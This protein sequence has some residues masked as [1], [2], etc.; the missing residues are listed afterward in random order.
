LQRVVVAGAG[1]IKQV[2][3]EKAQAAGASTATGARVTLAFTVG[4]AGAL[5]RA[6]ATGGEA[7]AAL[8]AC[9]EGVARGWRFPTGYD[10]TSSQAEFRFRTE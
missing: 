10:E 6:R 2:C 5:T 1:P 4:P 9:V 8:D 7:F 3:W